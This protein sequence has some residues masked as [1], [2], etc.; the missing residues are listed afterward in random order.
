MQKRCKHRLHLF[1]AI[2][3]K[4]KHMLLSQ[5]RTES[6]RQLTYLEAYVEK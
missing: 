3:C 6:L 5:T 4:L 2:I 1:A